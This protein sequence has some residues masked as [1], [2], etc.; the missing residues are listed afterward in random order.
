MIEVYYML[1]VGTEL[2]I[3]YSKGIALNTTLVS[4]LLEVPV[5][6]RVFGLW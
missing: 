6:G 3:N 1:I 2:L 4:V 5:F